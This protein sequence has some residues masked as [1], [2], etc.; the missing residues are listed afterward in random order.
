MLSRNVFRRLCLL[1][2]VANGLGNILLLLF[3]RQV[4]AFLQVPPPTDLFS[5]AAVAGFSFTVG[6]LALMV[7]LSPETNA[8]LLLV[9][10]IGK[11]IYALFT[12]YFYVFHDLHWFYAC[13]GAW[14][15][16]FALIFMLFLMQL[17]GSDLMLFNDHIGPGATPI[18]HKALLVLYSLTGTGKAAMERVKR[19]LEE[20]GYLTRVIP[21]EPVEQNLFRFPLTLTRFVR[22]ML[23]AVFRRP[24]RVDPLP[25]GPDHDFDLVVVFCQTWFVGMSAPLEG[26]FQ[27]PANQGIF[28][29]RDVATVNVCR[30]LRRRSQAMLVRWLQRCGATVVGSCSHVHIGREPSRVLSLFAYLAFAQVG[31]PRWLS[32]LLQ[33]RYG[34]SNE[35]LDALQD[36]GARLA[37]RKTWVGSKVYT[38]G[39]R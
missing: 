38:G 27:D 19:G 26:V 32:W 5:F 7:F 36:F 21:V 14:D 12:F 39:L 23:R 11:A 18:Q 37:R 3:F 25:V 9:G 34:L 4:F 17:R 8:P 29:G 13:F 16:A 30:G 6:V 10:A 33:P 22:I 35:A 2:A 15:A 1:T 28:A 24:A 20:N 31:K